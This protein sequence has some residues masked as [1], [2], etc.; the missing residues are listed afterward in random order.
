[1]SAQPSNMNTQPG[2]GGRLIR[3]ILVLFGAVALVALPIAGYFIGNFIG[4]HMAVNDIDNGYSYGGLL[5]IV[6]QAT[7]NQVYAQEA[8]VSQALG[9]ASGQSDLNTLSVFGLLLGLALDAPLAFLVV[10]EYEKLT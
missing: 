2:A 4:M 10:N 3:L 1:M 9:I 8:N 7:H 6:A 5:A